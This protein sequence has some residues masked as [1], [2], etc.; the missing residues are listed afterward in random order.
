[1]ELIGVRAAIWSGIRTRKSV[2]IGR[3]VVP[4]GSD[5]RMH[6]LAFLRRYNGHVY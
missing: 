1:M 2:E 6:E 5:A 3:S 4:K